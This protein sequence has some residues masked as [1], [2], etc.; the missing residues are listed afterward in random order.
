MHFGEAVQLA[1]ELEVV[2]CLFV[3]GEGVVVCP[4]FADEEKGGGGG[5]DAAASI[6][7]TSSLIIC[8]TSLIRSYS[9]PYPI[10][11]SS[12]GAEFY[13]F[14]LELSILFCSCVGVVALFTLTF[15]M[16]GIFACSSIN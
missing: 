11:R 2:G 14:W 12:K 15:L 6:K 13:H 8:C 10:I 3:G 7:P 4:G 1:G 5:V 9:Y 16:T